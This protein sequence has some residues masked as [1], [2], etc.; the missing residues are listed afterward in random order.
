MMEKRKDN[1]A[2]Q[3]YKNIPILNIK[4]MTDDEWSRLAYKQ[5]LQKEGETNVKA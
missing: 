1:T 2:S 3:N 4:V 5:Y